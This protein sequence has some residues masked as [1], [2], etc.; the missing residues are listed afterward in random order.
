MNLELLVKRYKKPF[1]I[2]KILVIILL[3]VQLS[4]APT[5]NNHKP[6]KQI[7]TKTQSVS[8][9]TNSFNR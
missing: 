3:D 7:I 5:I 2:I 6:A 8:T 1:I 9:I 4:F